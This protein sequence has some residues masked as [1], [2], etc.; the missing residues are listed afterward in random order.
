MSVA[1]VD[2]R[3]FLG[4]V[5]KMDEHLDRDVAKQYKDQPLAQDWA[6]IA[7][8]MEEG[9]EAVD[10]FIGLTGQNPRKG[11]YGSEDDLHSEL[12]DVA[13]TAI[14]ALQHFTKDQ[15]ITWMLLRDRAAH[16]ANRVGI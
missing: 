9:G 4:I 8:V 10:A 13:L 2:L 5:A 7:K 11:T 3:A 16:H 6:R 1:G 14:Y 15:W 12:C